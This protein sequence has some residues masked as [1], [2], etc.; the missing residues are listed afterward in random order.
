MIHR[1]FQRRL[2]RQ[3]ACTLLLS[4]AA[5]L[6]EA[7]SAPAL[8]PEQLYVRLADEEAD[9]R[10]QAR[11]SIDAVATD[12]R[13]A[14]LGL[15]EAAAAASA[16]SADELARLQAR[17]GDDTVPLALYLAGQIAG[18][19]RDAAALAAAVTK[20]DGIAGDPLAAAYA[21]RLRIT[22]ALLARDIKALIAA[23]QA[24]VA[25]WA[26]RR[27]PAA[28]WYEADALRRLA[29]AQR[30]GGKYPESIDNFVR[31][32]T[33]AAR[34][35]GTDCQLSLSARSEQANGLAELGRY[36]EASGIFDQTLAIA[37]RRYGEHDARAAEM[38]IALASNL[39]EMRDYETAR[40]HFLAAERILAAATEPPLSL[41]MRLAVNFANVLQETGDLDGA[42]TRYNQA[43]ELSSEK[44]G[45]NR[46]RAIVLNNI[47][48]TEFRRGNY[49]TASERFRE[50][51]RLREAA[52]GPNS[53]GLAFALEGLGSAALA[54]RNFGEAR[55]HLTR[56]LAL[57]EGAGQVRH[58]ASIN[59]QF[60]LALA[61]WGQGDRDA[62]FAE[63]LKVAERHQA[64]VSAIAEDFSDRQSARMHDTVAPASALVVTL[65]ALS[66][67]A[68]KIA[69]AW[70]L[71]MR[72]RQLVARSEARRLAF[73]R[74]RND[75]RLEPVF[76]AW[77]RANH[78]LGSA[79][80]AGD[81]SPDVVKL[82]EAA[83][84]AERTLWRTLKQQDHGALEDAPAL[85]TLAAA[86]P[87]DGH[88]IAYAD[89]LGDDPSSYVLTAGREIEASD[90][91]AFVL[92]AKGTT[93]LL[94]LDTVRG[95]DAAIRGWYT[96]LRDPAS[97]PTALAQRG[98][99][100]RRRLL[101]PALPDGID[102]PLFVVPTGEVHRLPYAALPLGK[103]YLVDRDAPTHFI[104]H[105]GDLLRAVLPMGSG[106]ALLAGA[107][108]LDARVDA[109]CV[110]GA[111]ASLP[112]AARELDA[113]AAL[114]GSAKVA[115]TTLMVGRNATKS[116][117]A[118]GLDGA[119]IVHFATHGV[120]AASEC[121]DARLASRG[122]G[123]RG[124][125]LSGRSAG[126]GDTQRPGRTAGLA[127][128]D[129]R[130][131]GR[132]AFISAEELAT[133]DLSK[134]QWVVL[135]ACDSGLGPISSSEGVFGMRRALR[136]AGAN[137][138][139]MS[140][141]P[142]DDAASA[143]LMLALYQQRFSAHSSVPQAL[144]NAMRT[145]LS[146]RRKQGLPDHPYY[147]AA[148]AAE[149]GW[150]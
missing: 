141:W 50:A 54:Q 24:D 114:L 45:Y 123:T 90:R 127:F 92:D 86:L 61:L 16:E 75:A 81:A 14:L 18:Q 125:S 116:R 64:F 53:P 35:F 59:T 68:Q 106:T 136:L 67:D 99:E 142:V 5:L 73:A 91:Y 30:M 83:E 149:G 49:T 110:T 84:Q 12:D 71:T 9:V 104:A 70:Q 23:A 6:A 37:L 126:G 100:V 105:E 102:G 124:A 140:L 48:N 93:R 51:L 42:M 131:P 98:E 4:G 150:K 101:D 147:W 10:E 74:A 47:G 122:A 32:A 46:T 15:V 107:P 69:T 60:G 78:D 95:S 77:R 63:A 79:W 62:A 111:L 41:R 17:I 66:G 40:R 28:R 34:Y 115:R 19:K 148:F 133:H 117:V 80:M 36:G 1:L 21:G 43:L 144:A 118:A 38:E 112:H 145:T 132:V 82:V 134:A 113:I 128:V 57:R 137:T 39:Q 26:A 56:A 89:A 139:V 120:S 119:T 94:R 135:S 129:A 109:D 31:L 96:L 88:L 55:T 121:V 130:T 25:T 146:A 87:R 76:D 2:L 29:L 143:D 97:D 13:A 7:Q 27:E 8:T 138:V 22:Q 108:D 58:P 85:A 3:A 44:T 103:G 11:R 33:L 20:L 72:D 52:E 65:A